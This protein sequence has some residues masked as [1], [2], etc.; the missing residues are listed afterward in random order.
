MRAWDRRMPEQRNRILIDHMSN[1]S[2]PFNNYHRENLIRENI[3][4]STIFVTGNRHS[5]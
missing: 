2:L 1:I 5:R 4:P 3:H